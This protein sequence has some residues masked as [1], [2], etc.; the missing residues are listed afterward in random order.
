M[1]SG[2]GV[3]SVAEGLFFVIIE[4]GFSLIR[5]SVL[6]VWIRLGIVH[7]QIVPSIL[8]PTFPAIFSS[9]HSRTFDEWMISNTTNVSVANSSV[10]KTTRAFRDREDPTHSA[11]TREINTYEYVM[12]I[13]T[14]RAVNNVYNT[15]LVECELHTTW[16]RH[17]F[18]RPL[19]VRQQPQNRT[20][21]QR[22]CR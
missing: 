9:I 22:R 7:L 15:F 11:H 4:K 3:F 5:Y 16:Y 8:L 21:I 10:T 12:L 2:V 13:K 17:T 18:I 14:L 20:A 6:S 19:R 1:S